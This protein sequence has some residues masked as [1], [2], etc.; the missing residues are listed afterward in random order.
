ECIFK[1]CSKS[2]KRIPLKRNAGGHGMAPALEQK[3][4]LHRLPDHA[5]KINPGDRP[6]RP[7]SCAT[8][9]DCNRK[10]RTTVALLQSRGDQSHDA[11]MPTFPCGNDHSAF[12]FQTERGQRLCFGLQQRCLLDLL[13][14]AIET[15]ELSGN[16]ACL[17]RVL[18]QK[19][20]Y[21]KICT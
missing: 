7:G 13:A 9:V 16:A 4:F 14:F 1:E 21:A 10:S 6:P 19:E 12:L 15:I 11:R 3:S 8:G 18:L 2:A 17:A 20:A 5:A